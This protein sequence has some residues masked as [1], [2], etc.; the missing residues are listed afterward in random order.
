VQSQVLRRRRDELLGAY[1][2]GEFGIGVDR[3]A[4]PALEPERGGIA[5]RLA[6]DGRWV[7]AR[8]V[9]CGQCGDHVGRRRVA[10]RADREIDRAAVVLL[11]DR[12][13]LAEAV[14]RVGRRDEAGHHVSR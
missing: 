4:E 6:A 5:E 13:H 9:H 12:D 3:C 8:T 2:S 10:R 7:A 14:V 11:G 1:A